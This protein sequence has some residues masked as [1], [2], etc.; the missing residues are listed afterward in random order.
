MT[1]EGQVSDI[2]DR[3]NPEWK[4]EDF[5]RARGPETLS[6][7]EA[8]AF[9]RSRPGRPR[10]QA[11]KEQ[12]TLRLDPDLLAHFRRLGPGWQSRINDALRD[13]AGLKKRA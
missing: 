3:D 11:P 10:K 13:A 5:A 1:R 8:A 7:V 12:V 4:E 6:T 9:P 2:Q